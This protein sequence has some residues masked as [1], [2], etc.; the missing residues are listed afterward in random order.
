MTALRQRI[1]ALI[2]QAGPISVSDYFALCLSDP[3][4]GYYMSR[5]PFGRAGDFTTAPEISQMFG[6]LVGVWLAMAWWATGRPERP[7]I[8]EIGPGRG[9]LAKDVVRTLARVEPDLA[10]SAR[11]AL[12]ETSDRLRRVQAATLEGSGV[13]F[14]WHAG[15]D[16][17]LDGPLLIVG[18]EFFDALPVRQF[19]KTDQ[20]WRERA[21]GLDGEGQLA[22]VAGAGSLEPALLPDGAEAA[23][24][25]TIFETAP[26]RAAVMQTIAE[27]IATHGGAGLFIDYGHLSRGFGDTLQAVRRHQPE[28]VLQNPG[29]ADLTT[30][31]DFSALAGIAGA[32]GLEARLATQ[33][34][35]LLGLGLLE[36]AGRLGADGDET[37]RDEISAA[38][39]RLAGP[40]QMGD[41]FK[42]LAVLPRG[43][44]VAPF[45]ALRT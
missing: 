22:F 12:I 29:E 6:E 20:G 7:L 28:D 36:R 40:D 37:R 9:T 5:D 23:A 16:E 19:V 21:V 15:I 33:G 38:V 24:E 39:Q 3:T 14:H 26:A 4:H 17:L 32:V 44:S 42:V 41:L 31:V 43:V 11:F 10:A 45:D 18:N 35:F 8:A 34:A 30:H 13:E 27:R 2:A 1:A 25:G